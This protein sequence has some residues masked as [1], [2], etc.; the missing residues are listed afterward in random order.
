MSQMNDSGMDDLLRRVRPAG[1]PASLRAR[2]LGAAVTPRLWLWLG[3]AAAA[4]VATVGFHLATGN[5]LGN[6]NIRTLSDP[7]AAIVEATTNT[8]GGD[9]SARRL[10]EF[11]LF[12]QELRGEQAPRAGDMP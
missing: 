11:M 12:E 8:L 4:L 6:A 3:A 10:A 9:A 5:A 1:P 2:V 7:Y